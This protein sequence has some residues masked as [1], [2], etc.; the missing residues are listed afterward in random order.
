[1][2]CWQQLDFIGEPWCGS[3]GTP[4][5]FERPVGTV[6][7]ACIV[8]PPYHDGVRAVVRYDE[9]S[10]KIAMDLKYGARLGFADLIGQHLN[11]FMAEIE[12]EVMIVPVPLHRWRIWARGFNQSQL[13]ARA[14]SKLSGAQVAND[15]M[16]RVQPTPPLRSMSAK[17]RFQTVAKAFALSN[18]A[19]D[20][21]SEKTIVLV[22]DIYT[23]G[24][25]ANAC[26]RLLRRAGAKSILVFCWARVTSNDENINI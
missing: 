9:Y 8:S 12:N 13:I 4:F 21:V 22:D 10:A 7:G 3:C 26:A 6:C 5:A 23:T 14:L 18:D 19:T 25:T 11:R 1:M 20:V 24:A 2:A 16:F 17:Q 15:L